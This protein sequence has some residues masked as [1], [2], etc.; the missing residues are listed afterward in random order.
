M[1]SSTFLFPFLALGITLLVACSNNKEYKTQA[2]DENPPQTLKSIPDILINQ[3]KRNENT[4]KQEID[5]YSK[6]LKLNPQD[7]NTYRLRG[8]AKNKLGDTQGSKEDFQQAY[9]ISI[10]ARYKPLSDADSY[11]LR[12]LNSER[13]NYQK[14]IDDYDKAITLEP[15]NA[16]NYLIRAKWKEG[17]E[18]YQGALDDYNNFFKLYEGPKE[19]NFVKDRFYITRNVYTDRGNLKCELGDYKGAFEDYKNSVSIAS[20]SSNTHVKS[21]PYRKMAMIMLK[22]DNYQGAIENY[23]MILEIDP[24]SAGATYRDIGAIKF[25]Q[26]DYQAAI[27]EYTKSIDLYKGCTT[28]DDF[29][30]RVYDERAQA[31]LKLKNE[32]GA[33]SDYSKAFDLW[34]S[35][36]YP[37]LKR[38]EKEERIK[39]RFGRNVVPDVYGDYDCMDF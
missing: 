4:L 12:G 32:S 17:S 13:L 11:I 8:L 30:A 16:L 39:S 19:Q 33:M 24:R 35:N 36:F 15:S 22:L 27:N 2:N 10:K 1:R 29:I 7:A 38:N 23:K 18:D 21:M 9:E 34:Y 5:N 28:C 20:R 31:K 14:A 3:D 25:E 6:Q 37:S 26:G